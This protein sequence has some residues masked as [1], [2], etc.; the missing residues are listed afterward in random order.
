MVWQS[1]INTEKPEGVDN[2]P[3]YLKYAEFTPPDGSKN[4]LQY[5]KF[6]P[7]SGKPNGSSKPSMSFWNRQSS[8]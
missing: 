3:P 4:P 5:V 7:K 6:D 8:G 1:N 2:P